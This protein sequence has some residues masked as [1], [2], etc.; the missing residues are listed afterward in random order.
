[1]SPDAAARLE[2]LGIASL[3]QATGYV[4]F[5]RNNCAAFAHQQA[6]GLSLG[7]SGIMTA[8]GFAFLVWHDGQAFLRTHGG[9][10]VPATP[11]QVQEIQRFSEDLKIVTAP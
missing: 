6:G 2:R 7:S 1:V 10:E 11:E 9:N 8:A 3:Q 4:L 5:T